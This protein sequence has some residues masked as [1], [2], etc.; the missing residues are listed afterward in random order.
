M[1]AGSYVQ[2]RRRGAGD[3]RQLDP[4]S[5]TF[6]LPQRNLPDALAALRSSGAP[7][8][9]QL[10]DEAWH[11]AGRL[12][13][14]DN[15]V[16]AATGT[17]RVKAQ[18]DNRDQRPVPGPSSAVRLAVRTL[19][20][21]VVVPQAAIDAIAARPRWCSSWKG[22][23]RGARP[24]QVLT[25]PAAAMPPVQG[26]A[27]GERIVLET[28]ARTCGQQLVVERSAPAASA[29]SSPVQPASAP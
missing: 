26:L 21:A 16:D 2:P 27:G 9:T 20:D 14:V 4:I 19:K 12:Q 28:A 10:P 1:V 18:F 7:V 13:F 5:V 3:H 8:R 23:P 22:Q 29:G 24:V 11:A 17:V 15:A 6:S 25:R